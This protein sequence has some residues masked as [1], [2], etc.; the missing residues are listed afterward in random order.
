MD[1][2]SKSRNTGG[3][4]KGDNRRPTDE[5]KV[6]ENWDQIDWRKPEDREPKKPFQRKPHPP[7]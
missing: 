4:G 1:V 7:F 6:R 5:A 3:P 2:Y